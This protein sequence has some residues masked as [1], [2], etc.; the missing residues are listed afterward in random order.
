MSTASQSIPTRILSDLHF[1]HRGSRVREL[2][3]LAPLLEGAQRVLFNGDSVEM[4]FLDERESGGAAVTALRQLCLE[5]GAEP[6]FLTGNHDPTLTE[7]HF[8]ELAGGAVFVT[9][10][11]ILFH[12]L[13]PWSIEGELLRAAHT[14]EMEALGHPADLPGQLLA[15]RRAALAI[16][17]LGEQI[18]ALRKPGLLHAVARHLWPPSLPWH[19]LRGWA[20]TPFLANAFAAR[21]APQAQFVVIGH[22]HF[23]GVWRVGQRVVINTGSFLPLS[24]RFAI[25]LDEDALRVREIVF[26][27]GL[28]R[29]GREVAKFRLHR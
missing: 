4:L 18:R 7:T 2:R 29:A 27:G 28:F 11:D 3:Q 23:G 14:R 19:I 15:M 20:R 17:H 9:H 5:V 24:R 1:G 10:G 25:D 22:T 12:G 6:V 8:L 21:H 26:Q 16:E 13:S